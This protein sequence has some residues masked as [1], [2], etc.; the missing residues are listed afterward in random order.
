MPIRFVLLLCAVLL[1]A[2]ISHAGVVQYEVVP[3]GGDLYRYTYRLS[4]FDFGLHHEF[5][6]DFPVPD[7]SALSNG[8][9][10]YPGWE[11]D[12][13]IDLFQPNNPP[14]L[15]GNFTALALYDP[16][17]GIPFVFR[18]DAVYSGTSEPGSQA[19]SIYDFTNPLAPV[20]I[21]ELSGTT[22]PVPE[23]G[24][25]AL[26]GLALFAGIYRAIGR[27]RALLR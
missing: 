20:L 21:E 6:V 5:Y 23:P 11:A 19:Y 27:R 12:W 4:G 16:P 17:P 2:G 25:S 3:L 1:V 10:G 18:V 13:D 22:T 9:G 14:G 8:A 24:T 7:F 26:V 15:H